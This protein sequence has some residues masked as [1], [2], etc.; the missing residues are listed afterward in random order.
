MIREWNCFCHIGRRIKGQNGMENV[1]QE[2][3]E[4]MKLF[5]HCFSTLLLLTR[6]ERYQS[7]ETSFLFLLF[8]APP[9]EEGQVVTTSILLTQMQSSI[10]VSKPILLVPGVQLF[11]YLFAC[12]PHNFIFPWDSHL[13]MAIAVPSAGHQVLMSLQPVG[14]QPGLKSFWGFTI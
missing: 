4:Q 11:Y 7:P 13:C 10:W 5:L 2:Q 9:V 3:K 6:N 8:F 1:L 14:S 12:L